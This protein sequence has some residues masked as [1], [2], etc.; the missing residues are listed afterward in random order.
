[1][2]LLDPAFDI[3]PIVK[4]IC[5]GLLALFSFAHLGQ[6]EETSFQ[7]IRVP[8]QNGRQ[9][10]AELTFS[11][12]HKAVE[13]RPVKGSA[14]TIP[15][16]QIDKCSYEYTRR[17][18]ITEGTVITAPMGVGAVMMLTKSRVHWLE[19][20]YHEQNLSKVFL[21]RMDKREYLRILDA[22][23]IHTGKD[24]DILGNA[25]KRKR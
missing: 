19:I 21:V 24:A 23:R 13:V 10:R 8:D 3:L 22:V 25:D 7:G 17:H 9:T 15:Y 12:D 5:C 14:V 20:D 18:R 4:K 2:P 16:A 6:A 1:M 11:D